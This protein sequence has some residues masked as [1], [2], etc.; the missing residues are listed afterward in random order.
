MLFPG[1]VIATGP[2][3]HLLKGDVIEYALANN[4]QEGQRRAPTTSAP[5]ADKPKAAVKK[6]SKPAAA[7]PIYDPH[8]PF[9]QTWNDNVVA[10]ESSQVAEAIFNQKRYVAHTYL[11]CRTDVSTIVSQ[12]EGNDIS[13]ESYVLKAASK[14]F[15]KVFPDEA[16]SIS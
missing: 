12:M 14:S 7:S 11:S 3:G 1:E 10:S 6:A 16:S 8:N 4:L 2:K 5:K 15:H 9:Q 13:F